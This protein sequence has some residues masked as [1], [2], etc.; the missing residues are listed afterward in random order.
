MAMCKRASQYFLRKAGTPNDLPG[1]LCSP[2][3][4]DSPARRAAAALERAATARRARA[5]L[6]DGIIV[7]S[8]LARPND[9]SGGIH[10]RFYLRCFCRGRFVD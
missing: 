8:A 10:H 1:F 5:A 9:D 6:N 4:A 3:D 2:T 7:A